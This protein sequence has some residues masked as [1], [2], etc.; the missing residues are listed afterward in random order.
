MPGNAR[1]LS[2]EGA[3]GGR[4]WLHERGLLIRTPEDGR[5]VSVE[6]LRLEDGRMIKANRFG[7]ADDAAGEQKL[8]LKPEEEVLVEPLRSTWSSILGG[9]KIT[10]STNFFDE[11]ATSADLTRLVEET[12][13]TTTAQLAN[14]EVY[15]CPTFGEFVTAVI[16]RLRGE[17]GI[18][19][20]F[21][22]VS[23]IF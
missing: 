16:K 14:A 22:K 5:F 17:D 23:D 3:P 4:V 12:R 10:D 6:S 2:V 15:M 7:A 13:T 21:K 18:K 19:L 9:N 1:E 20:E 8:V 11:G